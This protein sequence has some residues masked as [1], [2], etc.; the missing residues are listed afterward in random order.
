MKETTPAAMPP[1]FD[2]WCNRFDDLLRTIET[3]HIVP[4]AE[5][6]LD[7][8]ENLMHLHKACHKQVHSKTKLKAGSKA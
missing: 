7:D 8:I 5:G 6:G 2:K 3:H 1:C 4:V